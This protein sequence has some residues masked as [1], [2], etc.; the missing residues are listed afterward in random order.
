MSRTRI[1]GVILGLAFAGVSVWIAKNTS[2]KEIGVPISLKGEAATNPFYSAQ[3]FA[4]LLGAHT[5]WRHVLGSAPPQDA[6]IVLAHWHWNLIE[7]RRRTLEQWVAAGGRLVVDRTVIGSEE[8]ARWTGITRDQ[9]V[10]GN[11]GVSEDDVH[12]KGCRTLRIE[13]EELTTNRLRIGY[14][15]C[16]P[17][18][19]SR[20]L[21]GRRASWALGDADGIQAVRVDIGQG[22]VTMINASPFGNRELLQGEHGLIF[23]AATQFHA[24]DDVL[25]LS[26][27]GT[28]L[29]GL[30]WNDGAPALL[31]ALGLV[32]LALW[33]GSLRF[34]PLAAT[35][36]PAR[37]SLGEQIRGTGQFTVRFG[38][39]RA[40]HA[41]ASRALTEAANRSILGYARLSG[42]E[43]LA[44]LAVAANVEPGALSE[45][46]NNA[47]PRRPGEL[48]SALA[49]LEQA[50]RTISRPAKRPDRS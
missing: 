44:A 43:R 4:G 37:R 49:V 23:V 40:L 45:A 15:L 8:L 39:G 48:G 13:G 14:E 12:G 35:P 19:D 22:S 9:L 30:M 16:D 31:L 18:L 41:A 33:R 47:G 17:S 20:L 3:H 25:F 32:A 42:E 21:S 46:V 38:G 10:E 50:R 26:D 11:K 24:G 27:Q 29:L 6:I 36:D 28:S 2:W 7:S 1:L 34:G 5:E